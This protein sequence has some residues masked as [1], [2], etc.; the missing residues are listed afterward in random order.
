MDEIMGITD[1]AERTNL[2]ALNA[3]VEAARAGGDGGTTSGSAE[4]LTVVTRTG[5]SGW[6]T[7][8]ALS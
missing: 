2:L 3:N 6:L 1:I 4:G 7:R 8:A 5:G